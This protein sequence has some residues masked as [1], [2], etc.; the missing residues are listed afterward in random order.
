MSKYD[1][2]EEPY[3][4]RPVAVPGWFIHETWV[5]DSEVGHTALP[6]AGWAIN[7]LTR[8][9]ASSGRDDDDRPLSER[10]RQIA[11]VVW[12]DGDLTDIKEL[13]QPSNVCVWLTSPGQEPPSEEEREACVRIKIANRKP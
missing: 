6:L 10:H 5:G 12:F 3:D 7:V 2:Y 13:E 4:F 9:V 1:H 8:Y 11:P